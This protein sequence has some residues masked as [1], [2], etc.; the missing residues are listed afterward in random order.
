MPGLSLPAW[1]PLFERSVPEILCLYCITLGHVG[2]G[3]FKNCHDFGCFRAC[4][5][6]RPAGRSFPVQPA[7]FRRGRDVR[8]RQ[9]F[10]KAG[11]AGARRRSPPDFAACRRPIHGSR[12]HARRRLGGNPASP[13][14]RI[15]ANRLCLV[16]CLIEVTGRMAA[17]PPAIAG[18]VR[19]KG[20]RKAV[21]DPSQQAQ[22]SF[23]TP[24]FLGEPDLRCPACPARWGTHTSWFALISAAPFISKGVENMPF[25]WSCCCRSVFKVPSLQR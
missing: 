19:R 10:E 18:V 15:K 6:A 21:F 8:I 23:G 7:W 11:W 24:R 9:S 20:L 5:S 2:P 4:G 14:F 1:L 3:R 17:V 22:S 16:W 25:F 13:G 12:R